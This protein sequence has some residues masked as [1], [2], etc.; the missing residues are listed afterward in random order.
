MAAKKPKTTAKAKTKS[1]APAKAK[2]P[3][4]PKAAKTPAKSAAKKPKAPAKTKAAAAKKPKAPVKA[5]K[6]PA[7]AAKAPAKKAVAKKPRQAKDAQKKALKQTI[8][9]GQKKTGGKSKHAAN[10]AG[11]E[12]GL[13]NAVAKKKRGT[14]KSASA[15]ASK[16][17][18][19][20][21]VFSNLDAA[22]HL[23]AQHHGVHLG[24]ARKLIEETRAGLPKGKKPTNEAVA[25]MMVAEHHGISTGEATNRIKS[26]H[27]ELVARTTLPSTRETL[28]KEK[29]NSAKRA[30]KATKPIPKSHALVPVAAGDAG[31]LIGKGKEPVV[32]HA[33]NLIGSNHPAKPTANGNDGLAKL[34]GRGSVPPKKNAKG[35]GRKRGTGR[36]A[37]PITKR[38][39]MKK[40]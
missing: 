34:L 3:A 40:A 8:K 32:P 30:A 2:T 11:G 22:T 13:P 1:K 35:L 28:R 23:I 21:N 4:K 27:A 31:S 17:K 12:T 26:K 15:K 5:A 33:A 20:N 7:K 25:T 18:N 36:K 39:Q 16:S 29:A 38:Q 14:K 24:A 10:K 9:T 19:I 37:R 6:A